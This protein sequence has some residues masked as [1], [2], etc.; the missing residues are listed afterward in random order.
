MTIR[1][2]PTP[3]ILLR[4]RFLDLLDRHTVYNPRVDLAHLSTFLH[5]E[6]KSLKWLSGRDAPPPRRYPD[7]FSSEATA[8]TQSASSE[9]QPAGP[10]ARIVKEREKQRAHVQLLL[11]GSIPDPLPLVHDLLPLPDHEIF[12][13][14]GIVPT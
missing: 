2:P 5:P 8:K 11:L 3:L 12:K 10:L 6:P 13:V 9:S 14:F 1:F 4:I 7:L